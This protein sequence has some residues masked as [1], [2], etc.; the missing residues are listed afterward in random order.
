MHT[1]VATHPV[2][3]DFFVILVP[4]IGLLVAGYT[5]ATTRNR[6]TGSSDGAEHPAA[7]GGR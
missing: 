4:L 1:V 5:I 2:I 7:A 6:R 3:Y